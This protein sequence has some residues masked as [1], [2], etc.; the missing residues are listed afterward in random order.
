MGLHI[1][2]SPPPPRGALRH[3]APPA[4]RHP[5]ARRAL[6]PWAILGV[7]L[8]IVVT[9]GFVMLD[10]FSRRV[11]EIAPR[12]R[13]EALCFLL[14]EPPAFDPPMTVQPSTALV[15]GRFNAGTPAS[16]AL[17][18]MMGF[19]K[20]HVFKQW[21]EHVGDYDI[22]AFWL[23]LPGAEHEHWLVLA[24]M[25]DA[26]LAVCNFRFSGTSGVLSGEERAWGERIMRRVLV[27]PYFRHG[28][29]PA[30][31]LRVEDGRTMPVFG[32]VPS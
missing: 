19:G 9:S 20:E 32:P 6:A 11:P 21:V 31:R 2:L 24:W 13:P 22:A 29:L 23:H 18:Q 17:E 10:A 30:T 25:E 3:P 14:A 26:D 7:V 12:H 1:S 28:E 16:F 4:E 5:H 8:G 15:R 27:A